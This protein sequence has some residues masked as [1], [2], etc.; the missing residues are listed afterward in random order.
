M[1]VIVP[2][3]IG[4]AE[5]ASSDLVEVAPAVH[6]MS[7]T[8][9]QGAMVSTVGAGGIRT[10]W[11]SLQ[12]PNVGHAPES[13]SSW[14]INRGSTYQSYAA[15]GTF[16]LAERVLD[17]ESH[18]VY[19]S[20]V[21]GNKGNP[22]I[23]TAKWR[24][25]GMSNRFAMFDLM[26]SN[27]SARPGSLSFSVAMGKRVGAIALRGIRG[28]RVEIEI[29]LNGRTVFR[30]SLTLVLRQ[31]RSWSEYYFR[32]SEARENYVRF[33]LPPYA[34][35]T[36]NVTVLATPATVASLR[37]FVIG[38]QEYIGAVE[39]EAESDAQNFSS[40]ERDFD[41]NTSEM[42]PRR[43]VPLTIQKIWLKK[44]MVDRVR[45]LRDESA[46]RVMIWS[47]LDDKNTDGYFQAFLILGFWKRFGIN[48]KAPKDAIVSLELEEV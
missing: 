36:V 27:V 45:R 12:G 10:V 2:Y 44:D 18:K 38:R 26:R 21:A 3:A 46:G 14:W 11:E 31:S 43:S 24:F 16:A 40:V 23:D 28:K 6:S 9:A 17:P 48:A 8:Y 34:G 25:V 30:D 35:A 19:E 1:R 15:E 32:G 22:V 29:T 39:Y 37:G 20:R 5:L 13:G 7:A 42:V 4:P 33:N 41:G 47:G